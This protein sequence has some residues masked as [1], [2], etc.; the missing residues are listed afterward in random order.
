MLPRMESYKSVI[1]TPRIIAF[2]ETFAPLGRKSKDNVTAVIWHEGI[3]GRK[4]SDLI[5][6][7]SSFLIKNRFKERIVIWLDNCSAQN[8]NWNLFLHLVL[9]IKR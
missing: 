8:K 7:F 3:S 6:V 9:L 1:F 4:S 2:N 5:S